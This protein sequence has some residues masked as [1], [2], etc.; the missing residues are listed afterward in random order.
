MHRLLAFLIV[1]GFLAAA[2]PTMARILFYDNC[3]DQWL[4]GTEW[5]E[6][7]NSGGNSITV[8][9]EQKRAGSKSYKFVLAKHGTPNSDTNVELV[10]RGLNSPVQIKNFIYNTE[11]WM[12][13]SI[14]I[15]SDFSFPSSKNN[16]GCLGQWHAAYDECDQRPL[17][18]PLS[19]GLNSNTQGFNIRIA[20]KAESCGGSS[21]T[22]NLNIY[23]PA[24]QKGQWNDVV[25]NFKFSY[26]SSGFMNI[27][28][29]D[30]QIV[31][32]TGP[33][34]HND[35]KGPYLKMGI[36][37]HPDAAMTV[38]YD[39]IKIA[40][41]ESSYEEVSPKYGNNDTNSV[42]IPAPTLKIVKH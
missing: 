35:A 10:L 40:D 9:S 2:N 11:Y 19:F 36:Y 33:N 23:S 5:I 27:W 29:N 41:G 21:Y 37:G 34:V 8:S 28:L 6:A 14:Y 17:A 16:P 1:L 30:K 24:L 7:G 20:S 39:E 38:Y 15:P 25:L 22:R 31:K 4:K 3:E 32:D 26:G 42:V 12:G 18:Q 13:Y